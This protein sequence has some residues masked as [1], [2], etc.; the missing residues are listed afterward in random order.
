[1]KPIFIRKYT[2]EM[3]RMADD[4]VN[5]YIEKGNKTE[6]QFIAEG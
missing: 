5:D 6:K 2:P 1:M 4:F 3:E